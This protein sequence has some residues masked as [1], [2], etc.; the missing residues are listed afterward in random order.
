MAG[1]NFE[2]LKHVKKT[3]E[4]CQIHP[5]QKFLMLA[6]HE[7]FCPKCVEDKRRHKNNELVTIGALRNYK[8]GFYEVL[9]KDSIIDDEELWQRSLEKHRAKAGSAQAT[10]PKNTP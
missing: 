4:Y 5:D 1:L 7:P 9:K 6:N 2:L 8:R 10:N 3:N